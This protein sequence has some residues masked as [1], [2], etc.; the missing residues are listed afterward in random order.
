[1]VVPSVVTLT[2]HFREAF[3]FW[4][5][6]ALNLF[7]NSLSRLARRY[8]QPEQKWSAPKTEIISKLRPRL[9]LPLDSLTNAKM[10]LA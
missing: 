1:V 8:T 9:V 7:D 10:T 2:R 4:K 5:L 3:R 6:A